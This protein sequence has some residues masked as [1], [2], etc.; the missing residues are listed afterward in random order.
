MKYYDITQIKIHYITQFCE[1][2]DQKVFAVFVTSLTHIFAYF[3]MKRNQLNLM[4]YRSKLDEE[5]C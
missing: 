5:Y 2:C 1:I 4:N 3:V